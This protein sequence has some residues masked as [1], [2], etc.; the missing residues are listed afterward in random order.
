MWLAVADRQVLAGLA[1]AVATALKPQLGGPFVLLLLWQRRFKAVAS[2]AVVGGGLT[3]AAVV[4]MM[5]HHVPWLT[6][7]ASWTEELRYAEVPGGINDARV[8]DIGRHDMVHLQ[9]LVHFLTDNAT[10]VN[11]ITL[12]IVAA[13]AYVLWRTARGRPF[14][15]GSIAAATILALLVAYHRLYDAG[16][17]VLPVAWAVVHCRSGVA[18]WPARVVLLLT[19]V[20]F[21]QQEWIDERF[22]GAAGHP[23]LSG[24]W[25]FNLFVEPHHQWELLTMF[26]CIVL[27]LRWQRAAEPEPADVSSPP[28]PALASPALA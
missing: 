19:G 10:L 1:L 21:V 3:L 18:R 13:L 20:Y 28:F 8:S 25:W 22:F 23:A 4:P 24:A 7:P 15:L 16:I 6:G 12:V 9:V 26:G 5:A 2:A 17:I 27:S 14:D 11:A